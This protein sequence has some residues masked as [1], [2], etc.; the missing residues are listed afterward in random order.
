MQP[1][2]ACITILHVKAQSIIFFHLT[3]IACM[4][5]VPIYIYFFTL[6]YIALTNILTASQSFQNISALWSILPL[7]LP[8][9]RIPQ[10]TS[11]ESK[12]NNNYFNSISR[13]IFTIAAL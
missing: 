11:G 8:L 3:A 10:R 9:T 7:K 1:E 4:C 13:I 12:G 5:T 6:L 2:N